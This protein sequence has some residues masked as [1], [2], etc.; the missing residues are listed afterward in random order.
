MYRK[1]RGAIMEVNKNL[2]ETFSVIKVEHASKSFGK[3]QVLQ[4]VSVSF[5]Q[6]EISG[7]VG[8]NGSGKT[9]LFKAICGLLYLDEGSIYIRDKQMHKD[10][11]M[12]TDAGVI[13]EEPAILGNASGYRNLDYL[14]RIRNKRNKEHLYQVMQKVGLEPKSKKKVKNYSMGMRQRLAIAQ[15]IMEDQKILILDE[16]MN[17]LDKRGVGDMRKLFLDLKQQ[18]KTIVLASHNKED[19]DVLCDHVY[20]M[21][22]GVLTPVR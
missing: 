2:N 20:E 4:D 10:I 8:H 14:Y 5:M 19:I 7:I 1:Q 16:P 9:V 15:A 18:G 21:E 12:I 11:N 22:M 17:G 3:Q 13:I 6:G